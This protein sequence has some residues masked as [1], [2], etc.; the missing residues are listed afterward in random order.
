M[1]KAT[2]IGAGLAGC[3]AAWQLAERDIRVTLIEM[4]PEKKTPA[5]HYDGFAELVCS[6]SLRSDRLENAVGLLKEELRR[7]G[8]LIMECADSSRVP[9]GGAL[10]VDRTIFSDTVTEKIKNHPNIT[11]IGK[12]V[13]EI[14]EG[15]CIIATGPLTTPALFEKITELTGKDNLYFFDAA[16][17]IVT[18]DSVDMNS[19]FRAS[20]YGKGED[21]YINCPMTKEEYETFYKE[22]I[23]AETAELKEVDKAVVFEGCMPVETMAKRGEETLLYGPLKPVG[24]PDP[25]TGEEAYAVVQLRQDNRD[26]TLYNLVGFQTHLKWGEQKRVFGLIPALR[27]A[28]FVRYGVMHRNTYMNSP[29][30][31]DNRY[32]LKNASQPLYFAGQ[33]TGVEGYIEST[34]SG[35]VAGVN[36]ACEIMGRQPFILPDITAAGG[37]G[38][39]ISGGA[40][41]KFVPMNVTFGIM[42][43]LGLRIKGKGAKAEKNRQISERSLKYI[44]EL[45]SEGK[46]WK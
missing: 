37:L 15:N 45:I 29:Q 36:L 39:Y 2:V 14:P 23:N 19:A 1:N 40:V 3:E 26:G 25:K 5:H 16:A 33:M 44:D 9:A 42:Q 32:R 20:R 8:S 28:E 21:D 17:P 22:L 18:L 30:L 12:E 24:L 11:V 10:A 27:D 31:L 4:K 38:E 46:L 6:N 41:S 43:P 7:M 13:T 34:A 35:F